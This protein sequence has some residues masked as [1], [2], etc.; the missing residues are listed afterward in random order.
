MPSATTDLASILTAAIAG[1]LRRPAHRQTYTIT[2][3]IVIHINSTIQGPLGIDLAAAPRS[4]R[5]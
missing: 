2:S 5:R 4:S 3:P 1:R